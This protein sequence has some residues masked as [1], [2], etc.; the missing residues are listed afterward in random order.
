[1]SSRTYYFAPMPELSALRSSLSRHFSD[2]DGRVFIYFDARDVFGDSERDGNEQLRV[3]HAECAVRVLLRYY[4][5]ETG[6]LA[7]WMTVEVVGQHDIDDERLAMAMAAA[8]GVHFFYRDPVPDPDDS[9][10]VEAAQIEVQP[11]GE[12]RKVWVNDYGGASNRTMTAVSDRGAL[13]GS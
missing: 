2:G 12:Q 13:R 4:E 9:P 5:P 3:A 11:S 10:F 1:M 6:P 8:T 7:G